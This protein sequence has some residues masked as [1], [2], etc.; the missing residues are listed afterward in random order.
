[1]IDESSHQQKRRR[2]IVSVAMWVS[3]LSGLS[4]I[5]Y[6]FYDRAVQE[7]EQ[8]ILLSKWQSI[9][10]RPSEQ[11]QVVYPASAKASDSIHTPKKINGFD[12]MGT[13]SIHKIGL[14]EVIINGVGDKELRLGIGSLT[15]ER[16]PGQLGNVALA[17][18]RSWTYGKHFSRLGELTLGDEVDIQTDSG[19][20]TYRVTDSF[21][22]TPD[23]ISVLA[24]TDQRAEL[25]LITC[26]PARN[27]THRLI[28]KAQL[29]DQ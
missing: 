11:A 4:L 2:L 23:Q 14:E 16:S 24:N 29:V 3:L 10:S 12:I 8:A 27:P 25:T 22:V 18:H 20:F 15:P 9:S 19:T 1:M 21:L 6:P 28:V 26:E 5:G 13:I 7:R 17:G